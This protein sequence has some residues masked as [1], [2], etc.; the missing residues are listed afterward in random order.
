MDFLSFEKDT[1]KYNMFYDEV[2][3]SCFKTTE[4]TFFIEYNH[5]LSENDIRL[6]EKLENKINNSFATDTENRMI[7]D[8]VF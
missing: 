6:I 1:Y 2:Y 3:I 4:E 5:K 8:I 7:T